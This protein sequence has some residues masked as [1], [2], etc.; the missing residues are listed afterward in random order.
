MVPRAMRGYSAGPSSIVDNGYE[1]ICV[2]CLF[3][4]PNPPAQQPA[5]NPTAKQPT[6]QDPESEPNPD[7][8]QDPDSA[9][10]KVR[11]VF[12]SASTFRGKALNDALLAGPVLYNQLPA[13]LI[14]FREG[15]FAFPAGIEA[16]F[17]RIRLTEEDAK[18]H[19]FLFQDRNSD[20]VNVYQMDRL[21]FGECSPSV[22]IYTLRRTGRDH[23]EDRPKC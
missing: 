16:M 22:A 5:P 6:P 1:W 8:P 21:T 19:R 7:H 12:D 2:H 20:V 17:S 9:R 15:A 10:Q 3:V 23:G 13:V 11:V 4:P 14:K 18:Y